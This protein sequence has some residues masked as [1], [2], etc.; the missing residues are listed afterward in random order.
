MGKSNLKGQFIYCINERFE[1]GLDKHAMKHNPEISDE[2]RM[3]HIYSYKEQK[4]IRDVASQL[5]TYCKN[6][7]NIKEVKDIKADHVNAFL[8]HK[9]QEGNCNNNTINNYKS[10]L[11]KL[12]CIANATFSTANLEWRGK[13]EVDLPVMEKP[14]LRDVIMTQNEFDKIMEHSINSKS[15]GRLAIQCIKEFGFRSG[16]IAI[17]VRGS[18]IN[19]EKNIIDVKGK[20]GKWREV[21]I[22]P[23]QQEFAKSLKE[24]FGDNV[25]VN[26]Q[27]KSVNKFL[28]GEFG[29]LNMNR[30]IEAKSNTHSIR[31]AF[32]DQRFIQLRDYYKSKG[33]DEQTA[34]RKAVMEVSINLGH[35]S[36][37]G[38]SKELIKTYIP[39]FYK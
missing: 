3:S 7:Y 26:I 30:F 21:T 19:L 10:R 37:R 9:I 12:E 38:L 29:K 14:K 25:I 13:L 32:A 33:L 17:G 24:K 39:S 4:S 34:K 27:E 18:N 16:E 31:K 28:R 8:Q 20:N 2:Q 6:E 36:E 15:Q 22:L 11:N 35:S 5:A 1:E 23:H